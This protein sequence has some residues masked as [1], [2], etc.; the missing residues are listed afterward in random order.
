MYL[1]GWQWGAICALLAVAAV[2]KVVLTV[3]TPTVPPNEVQSV[4]RFYVTRGDALF[5]GPSYAP[6]FSHLTP[7]SE[8]FSSGV[9]PQTFPA[10]SIF[11]PSGICGNEEKNPSIERCAGGFQVIA[12]SASLQQTSGITATVLVEGMIRPETGGFVFVR[13]QFPWKLFSHRVQLGRENDDW[14]ILRIA[15]APPQHATYQVTYRVSGSP[16]ARAGLADPTNWY[17]PTGLY[18]KDVVNVPWETS[19]TVSRGQRLFYSPRSD[20]GAVTCEIIVNGR[21]L[22]KSRET[23]GHDASASCEGYAIGDHGALAEPLS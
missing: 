3:M 20:Y 16:G 8:Y 6:S 18:P 1:K 17:E 11:D 19:F 5:G 13:S 15:D 23:S 21:T 10:L 14:R 9:S 7:G 2:I 4:E 22:V 12:L